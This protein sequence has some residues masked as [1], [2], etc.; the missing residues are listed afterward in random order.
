MLLIIKT[1]TSALITSNKRNELKKNAQVV[2]ARCWR[3]FPAAFATII[4]HLASNPFGTQQ[5]TVADA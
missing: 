3:F 4:S 2:H 5:L 1:Y